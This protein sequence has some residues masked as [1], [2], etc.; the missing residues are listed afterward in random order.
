MKNNRL[1][2]LILT[3]VMTVSMIPSINTKADSG[4]GGSPQVTINGNTYDA[5]LSNPR[6]VNGNTTYDVYVK[7]PDCNKDGK[8][9]FTS[10]DDENSQIESQTSSY[11]SSE[12]VSLSYNGQTYSGTLN[13]QIDVADTNSKLI[14]IKTDKKYKSGGYDGTAYKYVSS[15]S[16]TIK[17][18]DYLYNKAFVDS[19]GG[20]IQDYKYAAVSATFNAV[21]NGGKLNI[22]RA[23]AMTDNN[24]K[25]LNKTIDGGDTNDS[26]LVSTNGFYAI[27]SATMRGNN[28]QT[29]DSIIP[30]DKDTFVLLNQAMFQPG[31]FPNIEAWEWRTDCRNVTNHA[32][33]VGSTWF[34]VSP[35][36][37]LSDV[38]ISTTNTLMQASYYDV[39][40]DI[41]LSNG[42]PEDAEK[43]LA[44]LPSSI[45][46]DMY[47]FSRDS[48]SYHVGNDDHAYEP[49]SGSPMDAA[50]FKIEQSRLKD[51]N[52]QL[53]K[54]LSSTDLGS[55]DFKKSNGKIRWLNK[56]ESASTSDPKGV[57]QA[58]NGYYLRILGQ[59]HYG[60]CN[61]THTIT[62]KMAINHYVG[63]IHYAGTV[64]LNSNPKPNPSGS[65]NIIFI[66]NQFDWTNKYKTAEGQ[67]SYPI[68]VKYQGDNPVT[69]KG[70]VT[71]HHDEPVPDTTVTGSD[72]KPQTVHH[73]NI[74]WNK[75]V[76]FDVKYELQ[77]MAV[78][79]DASGTINGADGTIN[80]TKEG[81]NLQLSAVGTWKQPEYTLPAP[82]AYE[83]LGTPTM[84]QTPAQPTGSS[85]SYNIDWTKPDLTMDSPSSKWVNQPLDVNIK[86]EDQPNLSGLKTATWNV[87]DSSH[88]ERNSNGDFSGSDKIHL[89]DGI[90]SIKLD[91]EDNATNTNT[92]SNSTYYVD[93]TKPNVNFS[94]SPGIF[95]GNG[96]TRKASA[97]GQG[98]GFYGTL[99]Y[100]DN[101]SGVNNV[102]YSWTFGS[103]SDDT[104]AYTTIYSSNYTYTDR[105]Q[106]NLSSEIEKPVGDDLYLHVKV[107]DTA[108]NETD[109]KFG[110][111]EDPI[112]LKNFRVTD[113]RDPNWDKVFWTDDSFTKKTGNYYDAPRLP[114]DFNSNPLHPSDGN[115]A[116]PSGAPKKGYAFYYQLT[117][118][119]LYRLNDQVT[120]TPTF[121]W[122]D[123][124][125]QRIPVDL[126]YTTDVNTLVKAGSIADK[127]QFNMNMNDITMNGDKNKILIGNLQKEVLFDSVRLHQ[128][129]VPYAGWKGNIQYQ[130]GKEQYWYGK[131]FIPATSRVYPKGSEINPQNELKDGYIIIN[132]QTVG[133][134]NGAET[135]SSDQTFTYVPDQWKA[136]GGP[137]YSPYQSG[138][139]ILYDGNKSVLDDYNSQITQ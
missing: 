85:G 89:N 84:P 82:G 100:S 128:Y 57:I 102:R 110:P 98:D 130:Y 71:I 61:I 126:Y 24:G 103:G 90:Y 3:A 37:T 105:Y 36:T 96:V 124:S 10:T 54:L 137:K 107:I 80:I 121:Y 125:N 93:T 56:S 7:I 18:G 132:F 67:G 122:T 104:G 21:S 23:I 106:E 26:F 53:S 13:K 79:G 99:S 15:D 39:S 48:V 134:K 33:K 86:A 60:A 72:G 35:D 63:A 32:V 6:T 94:V 4:G 131:Y 16:K 43:E 42:S 70:V 73:P 112:K 97:E 51:Q 49:V 118:E 40:T 69:E 120:I 62:G 27:S 123:G 119:Y 108:G 74:T 111:Y 38:Q 50:D 1:L 9:D 30:C 22:G 31:N 75:E 5:T 91:A 2:S 8:L 41:Y 14:D 76:S 114:I 66:P 139:I 117:S 113:V 55:V 20:L 19:K 138:D 46:R 11:H 88:Y 133:K 12:D 65:G 34:T 68:E 47:G 17:V 78:S 116:H 45:T 83:T 81:K 25:V 115:S 59:Y 29:P 28:S 52:P 44:K 135:N 95:Q 129:N 77:S 58:R 109:S 64:Q 127:Q 92:K 136:E 87:T 101:L